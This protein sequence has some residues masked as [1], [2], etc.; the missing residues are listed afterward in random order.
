MIHVTRHKP[1]VRFALIAPAGFR[2]LA[3]IDALPA[4]IGRDVYLSCG[5]EGHPPTDPHS[6]GEAFDISV[7]G[8]TGA[9]I[10]TALRTLRGTLGSAF[11]AQYE[12]TSTANDLTPSRLAVVNP[13]A[14]GSHVH[15]QRAKSTIYPP[16]V[17]VS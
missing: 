7:M 17:K 3:A 5:T 9:E 6:T 12:V 15:V 13:A 4:T 1:S 11:Y 2:I 10:E 16:P 14:S 8:W